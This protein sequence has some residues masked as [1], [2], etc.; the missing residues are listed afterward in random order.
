LFLCTVTLIASFCTY[1]RICEYIRTN[2]DWIGNIVVCVV[3]YILMLIDVA[4][5]FLKVIVVSVK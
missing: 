4:D 2:S 3:N 1:L 5:F